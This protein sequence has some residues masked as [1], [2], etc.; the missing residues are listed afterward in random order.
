MDIIDN[1]IG[2]IGLGKIGEAL[3]SGLISSSTVDRSNIFGADVRMNRVEE[4]SARYGVKC[5]MNNR[6]LAESADTIIIAV[7]PRDVKN[8]LKDVKE[9]LS[10]RHLVVS[11]AAGVPIEYLAK[12]MPEGVPIIRVMPN[13]AVLVREGMTAMALGPNVTE[14]HVRI[15]TRIFEAVGRVVIV[16]EEYMNAVTGLSGSGPAYIYVVIEA[17]TEAGVKV[18]ISRETSLLLAA[19]TALGAA[20]MVLETNEHPARLK[21][22]V[23]TPG[24]VTIEGLLQLEEGKVRMAFI[25]AVVKATEKS[26]ELVLN[27]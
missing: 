10:N 16:E 6:V 19:Q 20:K 4:V 5:F 17:L 26:R 12:R 15:A 21:D 9:A 23:T 2:I 14:D 18:G 7:K 22:M 24:G 1:K 3:I 8:A 13:I 27:D 11:L 25:N